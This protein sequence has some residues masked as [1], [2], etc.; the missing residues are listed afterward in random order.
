MKPFLIPSLLSLAVSSVHALSPGDIAFTGFNA[1]RDA[2]AFV[3][4][5]PL[6]AG[7]VIY[8][9]DSAW[10]GSSIGSGGAFV[11]GEGNVTWTAPGSG[12]AAGTVVV[13]DFFDSSATISA[14]VGTATGGTGLSATSEA[15]YAYE[16]SAVRTP[17]AFLAYVTNYSGDNI[18][19]TGLTAGA[20]AV[21]LPNGT[22]FAQ[23]SGARSGPATFAGYLLLIGDVATNWTSLGEGDFAANTFNA[24]SFITGTPAN[25]LALSVSPTSFSESATN[26]A[27]VGTVTRSNVTTSSLVVS[28]SSADTGEVTVPASVTIP[29]NQPSVTFDVTAQDDSDPDGNQIVTLTATAPASVLGTFD[30]TVQD[31]GDTLPP[32]ALQTGD[33]A[34]TYFNGDRDGIAFVA[35]DFIPAGEVI[36]FCD[37]EWNG[38]TIGGSGSFGADEGDVAWT[39][40]AGG[41]AAGTVIVIDSYDTTPV[42]SIGTVSG[43]SGLSADVESIYAYQG[44]ASRQPTTFLAFI[45]NH[46]ADS[47]ANTGLTAG[48][49]ALFLTN[50]ADYAEYTGA[51]TGEAAIVDYAALIQDITN[52]WLVDVGGVGTSYTINTTAFT[53]GTTVTSVDLSTYVRVGRHDLPEPTRTSLPPGTASHNLL[54]QEASAVTYNWDTDTLFITG[55]GGRSI[56]QV[57]KT[58]QLI[59]TMSLDLKAGAPQGTEFYDPEGLTYIGGGQ[60]VMSEERDRQIVRF[61][62]AAGTTLTR[63]NSKTVDLGTFDDNTG[64]EGLSWDPLTSGFICLKEKSPIG[65]FQTG[66]DFDLG[67]ATNGSPATVNSVNLFDTSLL[68]MSDVA[69]VFALSNLPSMSGQAQEGNLIILGQENA[70]IVNI[71][72]TGVIHSTLNISAAPG[73]TINVADMQHEGVTMDRDGIIYV[74][75]ENG[76]GNINYPQLW[77]YAP[78]STPNAA[79]TAVALNNAVTSIQENASTATPVKM[80]D[81][82][83]TDDGLGTNVLSLSGTDAAFFEITGSALYLKAG[84]TLDYETKNSYSVTINVDDT[85]LGGTPDATVNFT[86][87]VTDQEIETP[88]AAVLA[89]T[90]VAPWASGNSPVAAD[91]FEVTNISDN[92]V[93]ITGW[94]VDDSSASFA[95]ALVLN[96]ITTIA[97]G[98]SVIFIETSNL[99]ATS[100]AFLTNWF[101]ASPP[102]GLQIGSYSGSSIGLSTGGD[103]VN[104]YN[105][106]G[107]L[108]AG[109]TFGAADGISP[110]QTFDNTLAKDNTA[111]SLLSQTGVN[112]AF[113]A[114]NS[115]AEIGS[116]GYSAPGVLRITETAPWSS[117]NSAVAADWFEV[118]NTGARA[119]NITGWK[120]DD[121]SESPAAALNLNGVTSIAPGESVIF[122][123]TSDLPGKSALFKSTWFGANPPAGLQIG[124]YSGS[125]IGL[126]TGGDAVNL[127]DTASPTPVRRANVSF[128]IAPSTAPFTTF[129]NAAGI[130]VGAI[131]LMSAPGVNGAFVAKNSPSEIGSPGAIANSGPLNFALWLDVNGYAPAAFNADGNGNGIS[132]GVEFFFGGKLGQPGNLPAITQSG[133]DKLLTFT[134]LD[135]AA[136]VTG[137]LECSDDLGSSDPWAAAVLNVDY[138]TVSS[139]STGGQT[140]TTLRLL[141][142]ASRK[143]WR[144]RVTTN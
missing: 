141:G 26:P 6:P 12:V 67:T 25:N 72:R 86:L 132:D 34:F 11:S 96:G 29:A 140:T 123:E 68:G 79:P 39:A 61:T 69:D 131:M 114:A 77:V 55:D 92:P 129:D 30:V 33:I 43:S 133:A 66:V 115:A 32:T 14:N 54:C 119:V 88:P 45:A 124:S 44:P 50:S 36:R 137:T 120:V 71:S 80:G 59:D 47:I 41:V 81:I 52:N 78:S 23:Y 48:T 7:Q 94:K 128:G 51:R 70:R 103:A 9:T 93:N 73:D 87:T 117:G 1:D 90:E 98:E 82:V 84:V 143:F 58:G 112:G 105:A 21:Y 107:V 111:I 95:S 134:T 113:V 83:V 135:A 116:P 13:I 127:Y 126:S 38:G 118:T 89:I 144:H 8:F 27:A 42:P 63:A 110:Y 57:S 56:T 24:N 37:S 76:G 3:V 65:V 109:V 35:L 91:W 53:T 46:N 136:G 60:F 64:T 31:D 20:T 62:Y 101:G 104:L 2:V 121:S 74:V 16:G 4:L 102:A 5:S 108:Q 142:P 125:G 28:L 17:T 138:E 22:D 122:I 19:N 40:P 15:I 49:T 85:S 18:D 75:N 106:A 10:N 97:P 100:A 130:N 99:A 139:T